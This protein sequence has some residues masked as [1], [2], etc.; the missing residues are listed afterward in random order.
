MEKN[1][2]KKVIVENREFIHTVKPLRRD[3]T[4]DPIANYV[5]IGPRRTGKTWFLYYLIHTMINNGVEWER[6]LYINFEDERLLELTASELDLII[7]GFKELYSVKPICFFDEIQNINHWEKFIRRLVDQTYQ[8]FITGSNAKMLSREIATVLGGRLLIKEIHP[9]SFREY[10]R[11][12]GIDLRPNFEF[13]DQRIKIR[14]LFDNFYYFGGFPETLQ[15]TNKKEYLSNLFQKVLYGDI[16]SRHKIKNDFALKLMI[17]KIAEGVHD[18][19]SFNRIRNIIQSIGVKIGT[20]TLIEYFRYL[21]DAFLMFGLTN[22]V[23]KISSRESK[24]KYYF[25]DNGILHLFLISPE[26]ILLENL[27]FTELRRRY[28]NNFY[29]FRQNIEADFYIKETGTLI[30]ICYSFDDIDTKTRETNALTKAS[31]S[32]KAEHK[33]ILTLDQKELLNDSVQVLPVWIW[34]LQQ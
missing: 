20:A 24:K 23:A 30:Q 9:L 8:I 32:L 1:V 22:V 27:V 19:T 29:Y 15:F 18:E 3:Y 11:F 12:N 34:L 16:I 31:Q 26:T 21:E 33:L 17:K 14:Q 5:F 25:I 10:L 7:E 13:S 4:I 2:I 6:I 28:G